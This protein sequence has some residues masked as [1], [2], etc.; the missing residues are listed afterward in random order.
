M[1]LTGVEVTTEVWLACVTHALSTETEEIMGLLLGDVEYPEDRTAVAHVWAVAPQTRSDRRKDRVET[2][3]EQLAAASAEAERLTAVTGRR[4]R[5]IGWYHSHPHITVL[6]SHVDVRTQGMYQMLDEGFVGLIFS[7][8]SEDASLTGR[9][10]A[11]AFQ[12]VDMRKRAAQ[13][14]MTHSSSGRRTGQEG[15]SG[16]SYQGGRWVDGDSDDI[17]VNSK[18]STK[19]QQQDVAQ[20]IG[21]GDDA[22]GSGPRGGVGVSGRNR[23]GASQGAGSI[24]YSNAVRSSIDMD[25]EASLSEGLEEAFH[26]SSLDISGADFVQKLVP[27]RVVQSHV[28]VPPEL[29]LSPMVNLQRILFAEERAAFSQV[30]QLGARDGKVHPL[31]VMHHSATYHASLCK[32]MEYCL[33]PVVSAL[34]DRLQQNKMKIAEADRELAR[35]QEL[36]STSRRASLSRSNSSQSSRSSS[37]LPSPSSRRSTVTSTTVPIQRTSATRREVGGS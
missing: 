18:S 34:M 30:M 11:I 4:T 5:V 21:R 8:F 2:N 24:S 27:L 32:L 20:D 19:N 10:Q 22:Y 6:P 15:G 7:C 12:S 36:R 33:I 28:G 13:S 14:R 37:G 29:L 3:P 16:Q 35:L 23:D 31:A 1:S 26:R 17:A 9:V 25:G